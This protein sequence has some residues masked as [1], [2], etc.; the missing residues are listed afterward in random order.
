MNNKRKSKV[1][2][3]FMEEEMEKCKIFR[4]FESMTKK[5]RK[6]SSEIFADEKKILGVKVR[7]KKVIGAVNNVRHARG[8]GAREGVTVCDRGKGSRA[9]DVTL[10]QIFIIHMKHEF[11]VMFNFLLSQM[12]CDRRGNRRKPTRTKLPG[13]KPPRT[14]EIEFVQRTFVRDFCTRPTKNRGVRD[15]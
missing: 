1:V 11:K 10:I 3:T 6:R 15:V 7:G 4:K 5:T 8:E 9:C 2:D 14:I 13:Q 12:Y